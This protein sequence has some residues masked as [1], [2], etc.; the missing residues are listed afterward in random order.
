MKKLKKHDAKKF[1]GL[2]RVSADFEGVL[3][4]FFLFYGLFRPLQTDCKQGQVRLL[5]KRDAC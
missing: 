3:G 5:L 1:A 4:M 2:V